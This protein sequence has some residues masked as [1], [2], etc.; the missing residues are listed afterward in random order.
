MVP[1]AGARIWT[2]SPALSLRKAAGPSTCRSLRR[3]THVTCAIGSFSFT[4]SPFRTSQKSKVQSRLGTSAE[5]SSEVIFG[6]W[7]FPMVARTSSWVTSSTMSPTRRCSCLDSTAPDF[8][9]LTMRVLPSCRFLNRAMGSVRLTSS[10]TFT[11]HFSKIHSPLIGAAALR[12]YLWTL[13]GGKGPMVATVSPC[14]TLCRNMPSL[15]GRTCET[16]PGRSAT[17]SWVWRVAS[18]SVAITCPSSTKSPT[19]TWYLSNCR[20][21]ASTMQGKSLHPPSPKAWSV[22]CVYFTG[23]SSGDVHWS[24]GNMPTVTR[25]MPATRS[26]GVP[27]ST[28]WS[29]V[30]KPPVVARMTTCSPSSFMTVQIASPVLMVSPSDTWKVWKVMPLCVS[31]K[32]AATALLLLTGPS[33]VNF[34]R[35]ISS[36]SFTFST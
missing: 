5:T 15:R 2:I 33:S 7:N 28:D 17:S 3:C 1:L 23:V 27:S 25:A 9:A 26:S 6:S 12:S 4:L 14:M 10:P 13:I 22:T 20:V 19:F 21:V 36:A 30:T 34:L 18:L 29:A 24:S 31:S 11:N 32:L 16:C 35:L 8:S